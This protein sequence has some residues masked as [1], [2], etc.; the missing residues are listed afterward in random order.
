ME[1]HTGR[2]QI[3][4]NR[5]AWHEYHILEKYEAGLVLQGTE[6]KAMREG[7]VTLTEG[8]ARFLEDELYL[9]NI[10]IGA[11]SH[12]GGT[13][14]IERRERKLL[15]NRREL[16]KIRKATA[17]KGQTLIPLSLY[18]RR[19]WAKVELAVC[20]GKQ[21]HDKRQAV[22]ERESKRQLAR[23]MKAHKQQ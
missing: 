21:Q 4:S 10:H 6:A 15:L 22:A 2:K 17:I 20:K 7:K 23:T 5:K 19:G 1:K 11:Y 12:S 3:A 13:G 16:R 8:Y 18:F 14:H 9:V